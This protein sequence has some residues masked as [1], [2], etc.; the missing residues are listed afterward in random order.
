[1]AK[2]PSEVLTKYKAQKGDETD[3]DNDKEEK[4]G[5]KKSNKSNGL[6]DFIAKHKNA[7]K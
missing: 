7:N 3:K 1:M 5:S 4:K 6:L 2:S